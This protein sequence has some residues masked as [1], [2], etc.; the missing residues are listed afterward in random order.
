MQEQLINSITERLRDLSIKK[1]V[2]YGYKT[3]NHTHHWVMDAMARA[4]RFAVANTDIEV[5]WYENTDRPNVRF[6]E[7]AVIFSNINS[8]GVEAN[9]PLV[10]S[11]FYIIH[12]HGHFIDSNKQ[13]QSLIATGNAIIYRVFRGLKDEIKHYQPIAGQPFCHLQSVDDAA[14]VTTWATDLLPVEIDK[15]IAL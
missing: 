7:N 13:Y 12:D 3:P 11:S 5:F 2:F 1:I 4:M 8:D 14:C 15:N 9:L 6:F 10:N